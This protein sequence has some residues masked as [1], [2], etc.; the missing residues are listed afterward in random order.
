ML[1]QVP[2]LPVK[3]IEQTVEKYMASL[4]HFGDWTW[5]PH[6]GIY[7]G[8]NK[9]ILYTLLF[10]LETSL[11][12]LH[13]GFADQDLVVHKK[14]QELLTNQVLLLKKENQRLN[15]LIRG[16][17]VGSSTNIR[18]LITEH[19]HEIQTSIQ[20]L[21]GTMS[22]FN[23][24]STSQRVVWNPGGGGESAPRCPA[25]LVSRQSRNMF[26]LSDSQVRY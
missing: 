13:G 25:C 6:E 9:K 12:E 4:N 22:K 21:H 10:K 7:K 18:D 26:L 20:L 23:V 1:F 24:E 16:Y 17:M 14:E 3:Q 11:Y 2:L 15:E 8:R 5:H 19:A